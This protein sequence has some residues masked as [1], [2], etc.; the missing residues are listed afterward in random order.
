MASR[1]QVEAKIQKLGGQLI[2]NR[3]QATL[4]SPKGKLLDGL[5]YSVFEFD[6]GKQVVWDCFWDSLKDVRDCDCG[7]AE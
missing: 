4:V 5:H 2:V 6:E 7:C 3:Y 1:K